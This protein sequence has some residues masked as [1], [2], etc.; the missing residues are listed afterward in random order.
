LARLAANPT[1]DPM[2]ISAV[3]GLAPIAQP[4]PLISGWSCVQSALSA[5]MRTIFESKPITE[6]VQDMQLGAQSQLGFD[7]TLR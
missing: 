5:G 2:F 1:I 3:Q 6:T 4:E 7:C